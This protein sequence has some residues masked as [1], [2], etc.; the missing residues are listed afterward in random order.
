MKSS[1]FEASRVAALAS[2]AFV[3]EVV[4][5]FL[6]D[7]AAAFEWELFVVGQAFY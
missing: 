4:E 5:S 7:F 6:P 1:F 2:F 3:A